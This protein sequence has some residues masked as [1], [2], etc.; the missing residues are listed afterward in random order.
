VHST[1]GF[2]GA[3]FAPMVVGVVLDEAAPL[4]GTTAWGL[5]FLAM[6]LMAMVG[7]VCFALLARRVQARG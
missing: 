3:L 5:A 4:G 2:S 1:L 7:F 6:G